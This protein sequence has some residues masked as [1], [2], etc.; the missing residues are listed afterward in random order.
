MLTKNIIWQSKLN[1]QT[2]GQASFSAYQRSDYRGYSFYLGTFVC[3]NGR[4]ASTRSSMLSHW[5]QEPKNNPKA[6]HAR[7]PSIQPSPT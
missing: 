4:L 1:Q 6:R 2:N 3:D 5:A 7:M